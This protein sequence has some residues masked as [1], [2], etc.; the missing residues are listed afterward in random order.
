[1]VLL[2]RFWRVFF[3]VHPLHINNS[4]RF[5]AHWA[6]PLTPRKKPS[7][8]PR[9]FHFQRV[10]NVKVGHCQVPLPTPILESAYVE[11][12][13]KL[14][15]TGSFV[16]SC[17]LAA[18]KACSVCTSRDFNTASAVTASR[19]RLSEKD[20]V[21]PIR[22]LD[23]H[24]WHNINLL[25]SAERPQFTSCEKCVYIVHFLP[26]VATSDILSVF[27]NWCGWCDF[28]ALVA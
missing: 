11:N 8:P 6:G 19:Q 14:F 22:I 10:E 3:F 4:G 18:V 1:M 24:P 17:G 28:S 12:T 20:P 27:V 2:N 15:V 23:Q 16:I 5:R 13:P 9:S 25:L 21:L 26:I 7:P